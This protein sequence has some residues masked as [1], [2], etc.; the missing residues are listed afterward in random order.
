MF[1]PSTVIQSPTFKIKVIFAGSTSFVDEDLK[2]SSEQWAYSFPS[3]PRAKSAKKC[4][5]QKYSGSIQII[6]A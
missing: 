5:E 2:L 3:Y 4:I 6:E 1:I